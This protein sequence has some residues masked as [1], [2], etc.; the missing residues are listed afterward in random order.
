MNGTSLPTMAAPSVGHQRIIVTVALL[1]IWVGGGF[2]G[3]GGVTGFAVIPLVL[4]WAVIGGRAL[5]R[6]TA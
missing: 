4:Y 2:V 1:V 5:W 3:L 6:R